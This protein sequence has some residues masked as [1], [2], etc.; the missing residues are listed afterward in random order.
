MSDDVAFILGGGKSAANLDVARFRPLWGVNEAA[1]YY[2]CDAFFTI[3]RVWM[4]E[5]KTLDKVF[6]LKCPVHYCAKN[7]QKWPGLPLT[8][9]RWERVLG[10]P[11][12]IKGKCSTG[13]Q[14]AA[15][16]GLSVINVLAQYGYKRIYL[17]GYDMHDKHYGYWFTDYVH[18][19]DNVPKVLENFRYHARFYAEHGIEIFNVNPE[20]AID[21]FPRISLAEVRL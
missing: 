10:P 19:K 17:F 12:F 4:W 9:I 11:S 15:S 5:P 2:P 20:S 8:A 16:S 1:F 3:D 6:A 18:P 13:Q 21:A 7:Y 14:S